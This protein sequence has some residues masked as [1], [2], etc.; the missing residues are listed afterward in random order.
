MTGTAMTGMAMT[1]TALSSAA[2]GTSALGTSTVGTRYG[3]ANAA[4]RAP[5]LHITR[6][7]YALL[8][9]LVAL[10]LVFAAG[11]LALNGGG[12][13]AS[14]SAASVSFTHVTVQAGQSLWQLAGKIAPSADP[15][16]VVSDIVHLNQLPSAVVQPGQSIAIPL[17]YSH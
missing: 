17:K 13:V 11:G 12:A 14:D 5:R 7:G 3:T 16:D 1:G 8:T 10:P 4:A 9:A 15:R 2:L 6:R